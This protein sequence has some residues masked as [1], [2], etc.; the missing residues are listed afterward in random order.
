M[1][2]SPTARSFR[3]YFLLGKLHSLTGLVPVGA[4]LLEHFYTNLKAVGPRG[5]QRFDAAVRELQANPLTLFAEVG[6][7]A[8]PLLF[9][10]AYGLFI[11]SRARPNNPS[12]G[13]LRNWLYTLQRVTGIVLFFYIAY[14]VYN[15]RLMPYLDPGNSLWLDDNGRK[16][17][18][19]AYMRDYLSSMHLGFPVVTLYVIGIAAAC[20]HFA[21]GLWNMGVHW[22]LTVGEKAQRL[23]GLLCSAVFLGLLVAGMSALFAFVRPGTQILS[24]PT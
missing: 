3:K 8:L 15:T 17:V 7:I 18:S 10:A 14:H 23:S 12:Q 1:A 22:G 9:H 19:F 21:N 5:Q 24:V 13:H 4:F 2:L 6:L 16:L 11:T 20:F